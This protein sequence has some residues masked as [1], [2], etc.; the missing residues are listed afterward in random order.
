MYEG[1]RDVATRPER[2]CLAFVGNLR[3]V[4]HMR[5]GEISDRVGQREGRWKS[6]AYK[7]AR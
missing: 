7:P 3:N 4:Y 1:G 5:R 6:G 2:F